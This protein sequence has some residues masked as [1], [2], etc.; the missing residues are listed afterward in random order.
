VTESGDLS[1]YIGL[2]IERQ[3]SQRTVTISQRSYL[4]SILERFGFEESRSVSTPQE[5]GFNL[6]PSS[7]EE[8]RCNKQCYQ[9]AVGSLMYATTTT[10]CDMAYAVGV[11]A[12]FSHDPAKRH[13][14][15]VKRVF[16]YLKGTLDWILT[17]GGDLS[18]LEGYTGT[19]YR[20]G[21]LVGY[22]DSDWGGDSACLK[23][24]SGYAARLRTKGIVS[25][26]STR[27]PTCAQSTAEAEYIACAHAASQLEWIRGLLG[28][29]EFES[30]SG[31]PSFMACQVVDKS[32][33]AYF[34]V[35][36]QSLRQFCF[37]TIGLVLPT[38]VM[39]VSRQV[40]SGLESNI[41]AFAIGLPVERLVYT[42][43][44]PGAW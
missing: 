9:E 4:E 5:K 3:W 23:S 17:L 22:T 6:F 16:R 32:H 44:R 41:M 38:L 42:I 37:G 13:W 14:A 19:Q 40:T 2:K 26:R 18:Q 20:S 1:S 25:W 29:I 39:G 35:A 27:Q 7:P 10:R 8:P 31:E 15:G 33:A 21:V 12:R 11:L 24:T 28:E 43:V 36:R 30:L 34:N